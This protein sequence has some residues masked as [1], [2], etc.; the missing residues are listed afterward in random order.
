MPQL[1]V[2][3][4][5][6]FC[7]CVLTGVAQ[8]ELTAF[9]ST[10]RAA[11]TTFVTDYQC[12]GINPA[13][14]GWKPRHEGKRISVG[15][16]ESTF[17]VFSDALSR[18]DMRT[19]V[20]NGDFRFDRAQQEEAARVF[21][22]AGAT[23]HFDVMSIGFAVSTEQA[24]GF[25]FAVRDRIGSSAHFNP[26]MAD[27]FF[28]GFGSDYFDLL[29]L[30]TGD[31]ITNYANMSLDSLALVVLGVAT[32]PQAIGRLANDTGVRSSWYREYAFSY[33]RHLVRSDDF[34]LHIGIG[35]KYLS[36]IGII[37]VQ[38]SDNTLHGF[39][40][41]SDDFEID[42]QAGRRR[43]DARVTAGKLAFPKAV[44]SGFGFDIGFSAVVRKDWTIGAAVNNI[45]SITW[46]GNAYTASNGSL[47][48]LASAGL[49]N[50]DLIN[51]FE[52]LAIHS[53]LLDWQASSARKVALPTNARIGVGKR[54]GE[55]VE[56]GADLVLPLNEVPGN[57]Q[58]PL[59]ALGGDVRPV[60]WLQLSAGVQTGGGM[61]TK[62]P[63]GITFIAGNGTWETGLASRDVVTYFTQRN[64]TISLSFG[65]L[66]FRF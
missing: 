6:L 12:V 33:G 43:T 25:A 44:G 24:G 39:S 30:A 58:A 27:L 42:Y 36:G 21:G 14:L 54:F 8:S 35:L 46:K 5:G 61:N 47:I 15:L 32:R 59:F 23:A 41:L 28:K 51:G 10:G 19:R 9:S 11:A 56:V 3:A 7:S 37:D 18:D 38:A 45:G 55:R 34:E 62:L 29:V 65:F 13:N 50:Y 40:A 1:R 22:N 53:G 17:S 48:D 57:V 63:V 66:R 26:R 20:L 64:P 2:L 52:D 60:K 31:T 16:L 49:E 4:T